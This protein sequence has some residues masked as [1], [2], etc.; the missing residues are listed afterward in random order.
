MISAIPALSRYASPMPLVAL[1]DVDR[2]GLAAALLSRGLGVAE[3]GERPAVTLAPVTAAMPDTPTVTE[4]TTSD[5]AATLL[6][7]GADEVVLRSDGDALVAARLLALVRRLHSGP[8]I[9]GDLTIDTI[10]RRV[11]RAGRNIALLPREY[12]L[13]LHL[14]RHPGVILSQ[15]RLRQAIWGRDFDPGTNVIAVHMSRLR[16]KLGE[17]FATSLIAT[18]RG[19]GY[20]LDRAPAIADPQDRGGGGTGPI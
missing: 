5:E 1:L 16:A 14:A 2:P 4:A 20:R 11:T 17:G 6:D 3:A 10:E 7:E 8:L 13:P 18:E 15:S 9:V 19:R 12:Q